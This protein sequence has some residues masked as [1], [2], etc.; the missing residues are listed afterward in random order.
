MAKLD[1]YTV[2]VKVNIKWS[3]LVKLLLYRVIKGR[4][5]ITIEELIKGEKK[6]IHLT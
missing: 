3:H 4:N 5:K 2:T 1:G 6:C